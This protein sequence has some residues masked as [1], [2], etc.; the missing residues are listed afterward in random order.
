MDIN[1]FIQIS[2]NLI[3]IVEKKFNN[4][5]GTG[6]KAEFLTLLKQK[7]INRVKKAF[8]LND[9]SVLMSTIAI[10]AVSAVAI[11]NIQ[12]VDQQEKV[13]SQKI[14][15]IYKAIGDFLVKNKRLPCPASIT[16][17]RG[18]N[19]SYGIEEVDNNKNCTF[20]GGVYNISL[21]PNLLY[22]TIPALSLGLS[23][24]YAQDQYGS[25]IVYIVDKRATIPSSSTA[26]ENI[27]SI[28]TA[29]ITVIENGDAISTDSIFINYVSR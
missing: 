28:A 5:D 14:E 16:K 6:K 22:G 10:V 9:L 13:D 3:K 21:N 11:S 23:S 1:K 29:S 19:S 2:F 15:V 25:K 12:N 24:D 8:S 20:G 4:I 27:G 26:I 18:K 7:F 17:I